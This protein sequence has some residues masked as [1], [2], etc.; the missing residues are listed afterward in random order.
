MGRKDGEG[1]RI[2]KK[3]KMKEK[4]ER[5]GYNSKRV[6]IYENMPHKIQNKKNLQDKNEK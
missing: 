4:K 1:Q 6:R 5:Q 2:T 3:T